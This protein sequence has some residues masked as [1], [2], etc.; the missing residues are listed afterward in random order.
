MAKKKKS[1]PAPLVVPTTS[2]ASQNGHGGA[3]KAHKTRDSDCCSINFVKYV[4]H[5]FNIIFFMSGLVI[6]GVTVWTVLWKHHYV[7]LLSTTNYAIGTYSLLAAGLLAV[8]GGILGCCGVWREQRALLLGYTFILLFVFL[9]EAIVGGL[10]YL[11]ETQIEL[12][13]QTSLNSTF[14]EQYGV[15]ERQTEAIDRMQQEFSCC[16]AVRFEDWRHSVWL[17]SRR[18]DLIRPTEG[19][20]VPDSC[21]I[22]VTPRCG[23]SDRPSN[24][25]YTGCIYKMADDLKHHLILL[26]AIGL[27]ICVIQVFGMILSCCLYVKLKN[28]LD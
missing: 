10:A 12:E 1:A 7:S 4:L 2:Y 27:G 14:M 15:S 23:R 18:K 26:G 21:C 22:S 3:K 25:P 8:L 17:R 11:Y 19:R 6:I 20:L 9:L 24:I 13:L 28:V 5:I 16:G